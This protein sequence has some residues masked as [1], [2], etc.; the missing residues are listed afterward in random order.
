M[1]N[2]CFYCVKKSPFDVLNIWI[3]KKI[4]VALFLKEVDDSFFE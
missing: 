1:I 2:Y 3:L 4:T